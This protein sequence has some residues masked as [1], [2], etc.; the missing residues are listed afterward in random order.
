MEDA[1]RG[2]HAK[3]VLTVGGN[4]VGSDF[5]RKS[6]AETVRGPAWVLIAQAL[7]V[8]VDRS[9]AEGGVGTGP[10]VRTILLGP[11]LGRCRVMRPASA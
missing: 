10:A 7:G 2:C 5:Q 3:G 11:A 4:G 9:N 6:P 8:M 1:W